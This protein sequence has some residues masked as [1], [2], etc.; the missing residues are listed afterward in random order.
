[1]SI[2]IICSLLLIAG[3]QPAFALGLSDSGM[4]QFGSIIVNESVKTEVPAA[5]QITEE[6]PIVPSQV[7]KARA[8]KAYDIETVTGYGEEASISIKLDFSLNRITGYGETAVVDL[9]MDSSL[10]TIRGYFEDGSV[11]LRLDPSHDQIVGYGEK[12]S[13][14]LFL[15][16]AEGIIIGY[17]GEGAVSL[18]VS[19]DQII[20]YGEKGSVKLYLN[21]ADGTITGYAGDG[22]VKL[23]ISD[24]SITGYGENGSVKIQLSKPVKFEEFALNLAIGGG[25]VR[26]VVFA[27]ASE[28]LG[29]PYSM[30]SYFFSDAKSK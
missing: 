4:P 16:K 23:Q 24:D 10:G 14:S 20:G 29:K 6:K 9:R 7:K 11:N 1:M 19:E 25:V 22:S 5:A 21:K 27:N 3:I 8:A 18:R 15:N 13:V 30:A 26:A 2:R 12:G 17:G 28:M